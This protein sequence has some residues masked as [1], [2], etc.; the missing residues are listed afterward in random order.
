MGNEFYNSD[1]GSCG[2]YTIHNSEKLMLSLQTGIT[3]MLYRNL[4]KFSII[5]LH[6]CNLDHGLLLKVFYNP[7]SE[8]VLFELHKQLLIGIPQN[9]CYAPLLKIFEGFNCRFS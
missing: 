6:N 5:H 3:K 8:N 1:F 7:G 4:F 9:K 2:I